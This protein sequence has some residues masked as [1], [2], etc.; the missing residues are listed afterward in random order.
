MS[1]SVLAAITLAML[2][3][4]APAAA[5]QTAPQATG[6]RV[7]PSGRATTSVTVSPPRAEGQP[8]PATMSIKI[9]YGQPHARGREIV[10]NLI[11]MDTIWRLGANSATTLTT[12][13]DLEIGGVAVPKGEYTLFT[14][15]SESGWKLVVSKRTGQWGTEYDQSQDLAR[16]DL[17][18][19]SLAEPVESL[20]IVLVPSTT[21]PANGTLHI[22]WGTGH[23][24]TNWRVRS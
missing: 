22:M 5:Q 4:T 6:L 10:G 9:D 14:R 13:V 17:E 24:S 20:A 11:P 7:M 15:A 12:D 2:A 19:H 1:R 16:V 8:A 3:S 21:A 18:T 23:A